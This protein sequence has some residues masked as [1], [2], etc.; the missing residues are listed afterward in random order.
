MTSYSYLYLSTGS[1]ILACKLVLTTHRE[2]CFLRTVDDPRTLLW[3]LEP[4]HS[5]PG[6]VRSLQPTLI[7]TS[8][9][10]THWAA[11]LTRELRLQAQGSG[12]YYT[13]RRMTLTWLV[14]LVQIRGSSMLLERN[15]IRPSTYGHLMG[16]HV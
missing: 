6:R 1:Q 16:T 3:H 7:S 12:D 11:R 5:L 4:Q 9:T 10:Y 15:R 8:G 13:V 2:N 14:T